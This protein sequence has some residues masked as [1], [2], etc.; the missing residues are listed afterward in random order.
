MESADL[1]ALL[2]RHRALTNCLVRGAN[3]S[4]RWRTAGSVLD[5]FRAGL[6]PVTPA[7]QGI[8]DYA[9]EHQLKALVD[10]FGANSTVVSVALQETF[11]SL[12]AS[13]VSAP[14]SPSPQPAATSK[15]A[16]ASTSKP[17]AAATQHAEVALPQ[18]SAATEVAL[19]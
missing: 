5:M 9:K 8:W 17:A 7:L 2:N 14:V 19:P 4:V 11:T 10:I 13:P 16:A 3:K 12:F 1:L 6:V 18:L 15:P